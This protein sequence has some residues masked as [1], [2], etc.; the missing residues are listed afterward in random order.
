MDPNLYIVL[1]T[2]MMRSAK[3]PKD[4]KKITSVSLDQELGWKR[5]YPDGLLVS[6]NLEVAKN[7][8]LLV[9]SNMFYVHPYLAKWSKFG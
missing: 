8:N 3:F 9:V 2:N 4:F 1:F 7:H 5:G 6:S